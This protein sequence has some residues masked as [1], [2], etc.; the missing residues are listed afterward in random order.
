MAIRQEEGLKL[1]ILACK[2]RLEDL[3]YRLDSRTTTAVMS[4]GSKRRDCVELSGG[5]HSAF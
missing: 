5:L 3:N 1:N 4:A 2:S